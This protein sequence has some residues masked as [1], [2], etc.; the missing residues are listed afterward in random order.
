[1]G[2]EKALDLGQE[3]RV[4]GA[5]SLQERVPLI[6]RERNGGVEQLLAALKVVA[7]HSGSPD[8]S[9]AS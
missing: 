1:M 6:L 7:A 9:I 3:R 5:A 2:G 4:V 8:P